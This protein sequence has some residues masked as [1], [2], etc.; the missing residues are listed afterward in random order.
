[1]ALPRYEGGQVPLPGP[2]QKQ[3][4]YFV[5]DLQGVQA[6]ADSTMR[7]IQIG[8]AIHQRR[9][10]VQ[11]QS[12]LFDLEQRSNQFYES[13]SRNQDPETWDEL[14]QE[15]RSQAVNDSFQSIRNSYGQRL[16]EQAAETEMEKFRHGLAMASAAKSLEIDRAQSVNLINKYVEAGDLEKARSVLDG[17][18][19]RGAFNRAEAQ[20]VYQ[21]VERRAYTRQAMNEA[22]KLWEEVGLDEAV[23]WVTDPSN[24]TER[25][26]EP[27]FD[28]D[29][30]M[31]PEGSTVPILGD[32]Q[33]EEIVNHLVRLQ[34]Q[35]DAAELAARKQALTLSDSAM[36]NA[37]ARVNAGEWTSRDL[38]FY[39][40]ESADARALWEPGL[41]EQPQ[42]LRF[43]LNLVESL[44]AVEE[45][46]AEDTLP[47][48]T[49]TD[50]D[51]ELLN[52]IRIRA[53]RAI[54]LDEIRDLWDHVF[55][56]GI[57]YETDADLNPILDED[58]Q[59]IPKPDDQ[60]IHGS[61]A[62]REAFSIL[63]DHATDPIRTHLYEMMDEAIVAK[64]FGEQGSRSR[65]QSLAYAKI[66][67]WMAYTLKGMMSG[68]IKPDL[69]AAEDM[70]RQLLEA[71]IQ[72]KIHD[73][74]MSFQQVFG[75][76]AWSVDRW[77]AEVNAINSGVYSD[78][79]NLAHV[80]HRIDD[81]NRNLLGTY[82]ETLGADR[83]IGYEI[84]ENDNYYQFRQ[85]GQMYFNHNG[86]WITFAVGQ[87]FT[88]RQ[89][90]PYR[91]VGERPL[92]PGREDLPNWA[93]E[94]E[95]LEWR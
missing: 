12:A 82:F 56:I 67:E 76:G 25:F 24:L 92:E 4:S 70:L 89:I 34:E 95:R 41:A 48:K 91:Y 73:D 18:M 74:V 8:G 75:A 77:E 86:E 93:T 84:F 1:M 78:T 43:W 13:M 66:N 45:T 30:N 51:N 57:P 5:D 19:D 47:E 36:T 60:R 88:Q 14:F 40:R 80:A 9:G 79:W 22:R 26:T 63:R 2:Q 81:V 17:A 38:D 7:L 3:A 54:G 46:E 53:E 11:A 52:A 39:L 44:K 28:G 90:Y 31:I 64:V 94:W 29:G 32:P 21:D 55:R 71:P 23:A 65:D 16:F 68:E 85:S 72:N 58:G 61:A 69:R 83:R 49:K 50:I 27:T 35:K 6:L 59:R 10:E 20:V 37:L 33:R 15:F 42:K 87:V 62:L